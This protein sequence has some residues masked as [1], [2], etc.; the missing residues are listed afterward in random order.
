MPL[1]FQPILVVVGSE[2]VLHDRIE[3]GHGSGL[4][5]VVVAKAFIHPQIAHD[6]GAHPQGHGLHRR[7]G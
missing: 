5:E 3:V 1:L 6:P 7:R 2:R 4:Q